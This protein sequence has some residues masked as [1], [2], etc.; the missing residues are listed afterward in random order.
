MVEID[1]GIYFYTNEVKDEGFIKIHGYVVYPDG[2]IMDMGFIKK[3][4]GTFLYDKSYIYKWPINREYPYIFD[5]K[6]RCMI[7]DREFAKE[8]IRRIKSSIKK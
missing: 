5:I 8:R 3:D 2:Y 1:K 6:D 7:I 4:C